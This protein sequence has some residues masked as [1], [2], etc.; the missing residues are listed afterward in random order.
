MKVK[1]ILEELQK[2]NPET[3]VSFQMADGCCSDVE[4]L[5]ISSVDFDEAMPKSKMEERVT[6]YFNAP[7]FL[8]SCRKA[9]AA[10]RAA[11]DVID[12]Q[13]AWQ[14]EQEEKAKK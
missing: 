8:A 9:G 13:I 12:A 3:E 10:K 7:W 1:D 5:D 11:Q 4:F 14:K 6:F 2:A